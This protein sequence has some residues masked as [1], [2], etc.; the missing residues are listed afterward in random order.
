M[1]LLGTRAPFVGR[2]FNA[3]LWLTHSMALTCDPIR[4][5]CAEQVLAGKAS[6]VDSLHDLILEQGVMA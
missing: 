1:P 4:G 3:I 2:F 5:L 6:D